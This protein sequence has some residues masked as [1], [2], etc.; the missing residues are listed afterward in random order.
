MRPGILVGH[1]LLLMPAQLLAQTPAPATELSLLGEPVAAF[2]EAAVGTR[3]G[4]GE[5]WDLAQYALNEA[6]ARWDGFYAFGEKLDT[7]KVPV[8]R[9]DVVQFEGVVVERR[10]GST[11][12]QESMGH[13]TAIV[14]SVGASGR[15]T[16]A[17]Q[18]FGRGGRKV[19]RY[20]L[21]MADVTRG[22]IMFFRPLP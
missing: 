21:V 20:E 14:L 13:H 18:N 4:R 1:T 15:Y 17:H 2:A 19:S 7:T 16:L 10:T 9:G 8:Q 5:C 6:G 22:G 12:T 3:V 11:L